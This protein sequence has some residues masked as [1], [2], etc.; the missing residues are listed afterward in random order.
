[1]QVDELEA[2]LR[3][4]LPGMF[5]GAQF[6]FEA[7][8]I[9]TQIMNFGAP[10]PVEVAVTGPNLPANRAYAEK[11]KAELSRIS[12]L[13]DLAFE[14]PLDY[15]SL[16]VN[17]NR[18]M[19]GQLCVTVRQVGQAL[20]DATSSSRFVTPVYW[21]D[22]NSGVA[23]QVQ[24][25]FPQP[26]MTSIQDL[27]SVPVMPKGALHPLLAD[28]AQVSYGTVVGEY[29][30]YNGQRMVSLTANI[31]EE[32][33]GRAAKQV[34]AALQHVGNPPRGVTVTVR[35][36]ILPM[37]QTLANLG[38]G[39]ILAVV[40]IF[41]LL[42]ANFESLRLA[43]VVLSTVPAVIVGV[44]MLLL[45]TGTT[46]NIQSFMG[47]IM[48]VGVAVANAILLVVFAE[49]YRVEGQ[50]AAAAAI[51]AARTRLRPI[52]M[53]SLAMVA[54]MIPM[55]LALGAGAEEA[56]PLGRAV[57]GGL[58][59]ATLATLVI[60]PSVFSVVQERA[61]TQSPSLD[62]DDPR[63]VYADRNSGG[64]HQAYE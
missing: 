10:T 20:V 14:Q 23:Y 43:F 27:E 38:I 6:S 11:L 22:P 56:A 61:S 58:L 47:A 52:L 45:V 39:L 15:P 32:D 8:D 9:V 57:V 48:A 5:P 31:V 46:L 42:A 3:D 51:Q 40:V 29:D 49:R 18:Q 54:G 37:Q 44:I 33:L 53:T 21:A 25:Q 26:R 62:P 64:L 13:R 4:K 7:G 28:V 30:R 50:S 34:N 2:R 36:Q 55:A 63:S 35:G 17:I 59:A 60:L 24:V 16:D 12:G 1:M 19:T 41:L